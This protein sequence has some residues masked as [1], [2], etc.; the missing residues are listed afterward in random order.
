MRN[1]G[2]SAADKADYVRLISKKARQYSKSPALILL[3]NSK[4][5]ELMFWN[6]GSS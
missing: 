5:T 4:S 3:P 6:K 2:L 1:L